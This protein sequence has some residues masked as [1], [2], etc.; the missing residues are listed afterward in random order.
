MISSNHLKFE[1]FACEPVKLNELEY[2]GHDEDP[3]PPP[4][5]EVQDEEADPE[6]PRV[7]EPLHVGKV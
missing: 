1:I 7:R 6:D 3:P 2:P 4:E 5:A